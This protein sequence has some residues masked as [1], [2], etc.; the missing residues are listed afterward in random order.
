MSLSLTRKR[1][2]T[3]GAGD[4]QN[5]SV[6]T[7]RRNCS[8]GNLTQNTTLS[9]SQ[10][11]NEDS[12]RC[13]K[14]LHMRLTNFMC[15]SNLVIDFHSR[16]N[17]LVGS[18]G[19]GKS[20]VLAALVLGLGGKAKDTNRS[21]SAKGFIKNGETSAKIEIEIANDGPQPYE[22][23][24]YGD[25]I[26][27]VRTITTT[28]GAY[29]IKA[30]NGLVVTK[31]VDDL[32]RIL[33]YHNVQVDNPVFVLNQDSA[34]EFL[35]E[36]EPSKNYSLFLKATQVDVVMEKLNECLHLHRS[37]THELSIYKTKLDKQRED[38]YEHEEKLK[39]ILSFEKLKDELL[40]SE[41]EYLWSLV[42]EKEDSLIE[43]DEKL[44]KYHRKEKEILE[45]IQNKDGVNLALNQEI[46]KF[47]EIISSKNNDYQQEN[48]H[49]REI[50]SKVDAQTKL[51]VTCQEEVDSLK[52]KKSRLE[53]QI[54]EIKRHIDE[55]S[56]GNQ[57]DVDAL[58]AENKKNIDE[59]TNQCEMHLKPLIENLKRELK[60]LS[61]NKSQKEQIIHEIKRRQRECSDEI[62]IRK[63]Q[64][65]NVKASAK[66]K[67][68]IYGEYMPDLI[69]QIHK[70][71]S[72]GKFS[73]L[74]R[75]PIG[76]YVEV[77]RRQYRD[78]I[79]N[80]LGGALLNAFIVNNNKDRD[81]LRAI[82]SK[83]TQN[84][85]NII[86]T[87]FRNQV[88]NVSEGCVHPPQ[89]TILALNEIK[90]KDPVVMN[91]L[92][93]RGNIETI[94]ISD[95]KEL[96]ESITSN[97]AHVPKN[98]SKVIVLNDNNV[99]FEYFPKPNYRMYTTKI[100]QANFI[101]VNIDERIR[102]LVNEKSSLENKLKDLEVDLNHTG[103]QIPQDLKNIEKQRV[104]LHQ[105]ENKL[106]ELQ[107][108]INEL[109]NVE[110]AD[111]NSEIEYLK[112]E[113][114]ETKE[115]LE[116]VEETLNEKRFQQTDIKRE[117][118]RF[119]DE[120]KA[121]HTILEEIQNEIESYKTKSHQIKMKLRSVN[122]N[123]SL[124]REK[125][126]EIKEKL[127]K[128]Q[129]DRNEIAKA[130]KQAKTAAKEKGERVDTKENLEEI[131]EKIAKIKAQ[132][133]HGLPVN[134]DPQEL[135]E[136]I[137]TKK[138]SLE[139]NEGT[140]ENIK[141]SILMLRKSLKFRFDFLKKLKEHMAVI[142]QL[143]FS[144]ILKLRNFEGTIDI[145]HQEKK[146]KI[147]VIPRDH[148][149]NAV[150]STK[151]LSGGERSY[152]TVAFLIS[153]WSCVDHPFYFLDE[154]D[155][156]TDEVNREYMTRLLIDEGRKR[157]L[158]QYSF[159][160]PQDM[161]LVPEHFIKIHRLA[162]P[163]RR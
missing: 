80:I 135:R 31:K 156:F 92:I 40:N 115:R 120:L 140:F 20:A 129:C 5:E 33:M 89:G 52:K 69:N 137:A 61:D 158:R 94:L 19:S 139:A 86:T 23:Y 90:C 55:R 73:Q 116:K 100:R 26:T 151:A 114:D 154:Y 62:R 38:I 12:R 16:V 67:L 108:K 81:T 64:I 149:K 111:Y 112:K 117:K 104:K 21:S 91:C 155:V 132:L 134:L 78:V 133:K 162:E 29:A 48:M 136:L 146:L 68:S 110:Y 147:S 60:V 82:L 44:E 130:L 3:S 107:E 57:D 32:H 161:T 43:I 105:H 65:E 113:M 71:N 30:A 36:L 122:N 103:Q 163:D 9:Q 88:H 157:A 25:K 6:S 58:R 142:L 152:S 10:R 1:N 148:N 72:E 75:G 126:T 50:K 95:S 106:A 143:S 93:D 138:E 49:Y 8:H 74:P 141:I 59:F 14:I 54:E 7:K 144:M 79:E 56:K 18:N 160:T 28:S 121:Q 84:P 96:A 97:R 17:F 159:L 83:F 118:E 102:N 153:L 39:Q 27:I 124:S 85:P 76:N 127:N 13:G 51:T 131:R 11:L 101:Q 15:H 47:D 77:P 34:R 4:A 41:I 63:V 24:V 123:E 87:A 37:H 2:R 145:D 150:S 42:K 45:T 128:Y 98:L 99:I 46:K 70:A 125:L 66:N 109:Q 22:P 53:T 119:E 35:K